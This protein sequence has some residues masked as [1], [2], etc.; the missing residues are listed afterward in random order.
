MSQTDYALWR[1][2]CARPANALSCKAMKSAPPEAA[3]ARPVI[4]AADIRDAVAIFDLIRANP[5]ELIARPLGDIVQHIDRFVVADEAGAIAGCAS[6]GILPEVG[7]TS[8]ASIEIKSVAVKPAWRRHGL[9]R[10]LVLAV[11][12]R[13]APLRLSQLIV[14]T[15]TPPFFAKLGFV[16]IP[17][18]QIMHKIYSGCL[19][20][21]KHANPFTCPEVAMEMRPPPPLR[22]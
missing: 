1:A 9:G 3:P 6:W 8:R 22:P 20:C 10:A 16:E 21:T 18:T 12:E 13:V 17:K 11:I 4:R 15:F 5:D 7:D 19:A 2:C 14:L